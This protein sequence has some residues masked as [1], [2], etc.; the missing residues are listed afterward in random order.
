MRRAVRKYAAGVLLATLA[1]CTNAA[2]ATSYTM[3][4]DPQCGC[5]EAWADHVSDNMDARVATVDEPNMSAFKD[6]QNVPQDLRSC[7]TMIVSGYV[8]EGHVP[9]DAI[10]KLLREQ[11]QGVDGLAVAGMP[12]GSPG[13]EMGAQRQ[14]Y[15]VIA[16]GNAGRRVF[17]RY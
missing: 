8:I 12:L 2:Q 7:H 3:H 6:A 14:S 15:E 1:A 11:P 16:F 13:M 9:A 5:C 17:A 10:A 4:R